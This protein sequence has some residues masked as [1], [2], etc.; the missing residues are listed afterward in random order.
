MQF[1]LFNFSW[2]DKGEYIL[3]I[4]ENNYSFNRDHLK[5]WIRHLLELTLEIILDM[6]DEKKGD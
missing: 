6:I 5:Y 2:N 1:E 3:M 4:G